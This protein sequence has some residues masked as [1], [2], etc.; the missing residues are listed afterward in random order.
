MKLTIA[1][2]GLTMTSCD[3]TKS[4]LFTESDSLLRRLKIN[5]CL[6]A[7][8]KQQRRPVGHAMACTT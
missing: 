8:T 3:S 5:F 6:V 7:V 4:V 1:V 2:N